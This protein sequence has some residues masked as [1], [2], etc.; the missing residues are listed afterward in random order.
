MQLYPS[1]LIRF[2]QGLIFHQ[3][4]LFM[5]LI[6]LYLLPFVYVY[7]A[8]GSDFYVIPIYI[9]VLADSLCEL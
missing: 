2:K 7:D 8:H 9:H 4:K 1:L 6:H 3:N 5:P